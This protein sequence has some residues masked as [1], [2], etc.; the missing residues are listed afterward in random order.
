MDGQGVNPPDQLSLLGLAVERLA[1][2]VADLEQRVAGDLSNV[3]QE[4]G[5][6]GHRGNLLQAEVQALQLVVAGIPRGGGG[7]GQNRQRFKI[8]APRKFSEADGT[9]TL[10][11]WLHSLRVY[12]EFCDAQPTGAQLAAYLDGA[13]LTAFNSHQASCT[14]DQR[15]SD[16]D[17]FERV[18]KVLMNLGNNPEVARQKMK[19][20][21]Q[22]NSHISEYNTTFAALAAE[23]PDRSAFDMVGDYI[24]GL[25]DDIRRDVKMQSCSTLAEAMQKAVAASGISMASAIT[26]VAS[27]TNGGASSSG[28]H[29][30]MEVEGTRL[31]EAI[32]RILTGQD[33]AQPRQGK[34]DGRKVQCYNCDG[35]G[36]FS[37]DCPRPKREKG[38]KK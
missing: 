27:G 21:R 7:G 3:V 13:A 36:H 31:N 34:G 30:P 32:L 18:M 20:L 25:C 33:V 26:L 11:P 29:V 12:V 8:P 2:R 16:L 38:A 17:S 35:Y 22:G 5:H 28:G 19:Q 14:P 15:V 9:R 23:C 10:V 4:I 37:R 6:V 1:A 24:D